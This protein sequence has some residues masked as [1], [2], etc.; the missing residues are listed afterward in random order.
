MAVRS[1]TD[2]FILMRNNALQN[3]NVFN[4]LHSNEFDE[5]DRVALVGNRKNKEPKASYAKS[6]F[7]IEWSDISHDIQ[8]D[9]EKIEEKVQE[10]F[11]MHER[12]LTRPTLDDT[13]DEEQGIEVCTQEI[14]HLFHKCNDSIK[15]LGKYKLRCN[16]QEKIMLNN[17][18]S[19]Y[20][21][22]L[23]HLSIDFRKQQSNYLKKLKAR[24]ER[25]HQYFKSD[26]AIMVE[27]DDITDDFF[28]KGFSGNQVAIVQQN[29]VNIEQ[30][31]EEIR[32]VV[33]SITEL[34]E[35]FKDLSQIVVEQG[36]VLDR[37]D[38]NIENTVVKTEA[39]LQQLQKAE[40]YQKKNRKMMVIFILAVIAIILFII[41][42]VTKGR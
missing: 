25:S 18:I 5:D 19:S 40:T 23:Q 30:R 7:S 26:T 33:Q 13:F 34:S 32:S 9:V 16:E 17:A 31:E 6:S 38:Y 29:T 2:V 24:E 21:A 42:I 37:I 36:T 1:L 20:A 39:G 10:L 4:R 27:E 3:K 35:I 15:T 11:L 41:L 12:H 14:T 28:E 22:N 8:Y